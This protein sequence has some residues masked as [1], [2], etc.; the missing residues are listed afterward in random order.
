MQL[1]KISSVCFRKMA[2]TAPYMTPIQ[3]NW[4][5]W[6]SFISQFTRRFWFSSNTLSQLALFSH[7]IDI[8]LSVG[9]RR[10][11]D[12]SDAIVAGFLYVCIYL[13]IFLR[14]VVGFRARFHNGHLAP[15]EVSC[16]KRQ[17]TLR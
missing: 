6:Q 14:L 13:S 9:P 17:T 2:T 3:Q 7:R 15:S 8:N 5:T 1:T 16:L 11:S 10:P 12:Q 4:S